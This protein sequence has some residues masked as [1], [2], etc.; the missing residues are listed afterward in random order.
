MMPRFALIVL[1]LPIAAQDQPQNPPQLKDSVIVT[2]VYEPAPLE[3]ADRAVRVIDLNAD[4]KLL[5]NTVFDFLRL[6]PSLDVASRAPNGVQT[7]ISIRGGT[8]GQ[9]LVLLDGVRL[10]DAQSGHHDL[11]I[12]VPPDAA[13]RIEVLKGAG[14][15][16]YGSDA[17]GGV[18]NIITRAP[19]ANELD[20]RAG[21]GNF[22]V[23]QQSGALTTVWPALTEQLSFSRDFS[24]GF[25]DDR[26]YRNLSLA[27]I[28]HLRTR[29]GTTDVTLASN[30]R[31]F[32][33]NQFYGP[34]NEWERTRSW[35]AAIRQALG[36]NTE[37]SFAFR[38][39]T[40]LFVLLRNDPQY[41][42]NRH[43]VEGYQA[44]VRRHNRVSQNGTLSYGGEAFRD[45]IDSTNLGDHQRN[46]GAAYLALDV[47]ALKRYSFT[48]GA[49]EEIFKGGARQLSPTAA[50]GAWLSEH[51]KLRASANRAFRLPSYTDLYYHDPANLGSPYLKP[52][53]AWGYDGAIEWYAGRRLSGDAGVFYQRV[54]DGI[55]Y[56]RASPADVW[57]AANIDR[58]NFTGF[59]AS[60]LVHPVP[61]QTVEVRYTGLHG[62]Q[63]AL[64]GLQSEYV[65]NY[66]THDAILTWQAA[67]PAGFIARTRIA[68]L[69]RY[70][71]DPYG[72]W[73]LYVADRRGRWSPFL[74]L[75]NITSTTYQEVLGVAMPGRA[76]VGGID[77]RFGW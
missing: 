70:G 61:T 7:D 12:P 15:A 23:N 19:E 66:P 65:F 52:E 17:V 32:G 31:P 1:V 59:E 8:F 54:R 22:G 11:D 2:G 35:F 24:T 30:D 69:Q 37:I 64:N 71:R 44:A 28:T 43:A 40:D 9:T 62:A 50:A 13:G 53:T 26:D 5:A 14:S 10:N 46:Y 16:I 57:Q 25:M 47:R 18:I 45:Q 74:Q 39:H 38:R 73:D 49:R 55:D 3:E 34:Y 33:A 67:L 42:T 58:L 29:L 27:S 4:Q 72:L 20:L 56:V 36:R 68:V 48:I 21:I 60:L 41:F 76:V 6:D 77:W 51:W 63:D 75:T